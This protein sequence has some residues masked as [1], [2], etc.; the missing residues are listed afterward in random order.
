MHAP[1]NSRNDVSAS[2]QRLGIRLL[3][4]LGAY[5]RLARMHRPIG[6][7]LLLWPTLWALWIAGRGHP[8]TLHFAVFVAGTF[9][10]RCAGCAINDFADRGIDSQVRRTRDRPLA[11]G[12]IRPAE[13]VA[14]FVV[15]AIAAFFLA[16]F[17]L[18]RLALLL[19]I[20]GVLLAAS[21]PFV[22]RI[23]HLPQ[24]YLG[25]AFGWGIPMAFAAEAHAL[26]PVCWLLLGVN[27][28]WA[29]VYDTFYAMAD[30]PDD[31]RIGVRSTA[32]LFGRADR[33]II[34]VLQLLVLIGLAVA[35]WWRE[36]GAVY[37]W[38]LGAAAGFA[39]YQQ[40]LARNR[41]PARCFAA[42]LNN[43]WFGAAVFAGIILQANL[44]V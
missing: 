34:A 7:F 2:P 12:E 20:P 29:T 23:T 1:E 33:T 17:T 27:V 19:A 30:R 36:L 32:I 38:G 4:R 9:L 39:L 37:Y 28:L 40:W 10:M 24:L 22:K 13:A 21:Y 8:T 25:V 15:F 43:N 5:A 41:E 3:R 6:T 18:D 26:P 35:G 42:F 31:E 44:R 11:R 14:V 16:F